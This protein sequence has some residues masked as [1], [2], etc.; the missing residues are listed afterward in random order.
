MLLEAKWLTLA[1]SREGRGGDGK[2]E[3][4]R[5]E[6]GWGGEER[7]GEERG[8]GGEE[9]RALIS[10]YPQEGSL[11]GTVAPLAYF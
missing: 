7:G 6:E 4:G 8:G 5:G 3:D 11:C 1:Q 2:G 10:S 9:I